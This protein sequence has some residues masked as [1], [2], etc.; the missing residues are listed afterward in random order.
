MN[1]GVHS[2]STCRKALGGSEEHEIIW[3]INDHPILHL[4]RV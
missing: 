4:N 1:G 2:E 3:G